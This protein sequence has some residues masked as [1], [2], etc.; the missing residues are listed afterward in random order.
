VARLLDL[1]CGAGGAAMGY[2]RAG[3]EVVG[4][5]I[6]P[7][8]HYPF[9]FTQADALAFPLDGF[10]AIH[11]SPVCKRWS[12]VTR[13]SVD[14]E[15]HPDTLT[16]IRERFLTEAIVPWVIENVPCAPLIDPIMLCG[17]MFDLDVQR[18]R[19]FETNW[20]L[21]DHHWPC[22]HGIWAPRYA[23]NRSD[24]KRNPNALARVTSVAGGGGGGHGQRMDDWKR[25]MGIDWMPRDR[26]AQAIPPAYTEFIGGQLL[27]H[28]DARS[29]A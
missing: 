9:E 16:P 14:P 26:L 24:R 27:A 20:G 6:E 28:L 2:H 21:V 17:S 1:F 19:L 12:Q 5:D 11:A 7:Q 4:V 29:A 13:T 8:S 10:D 22:R 15:S 25:A 18:H 23:P 3:F